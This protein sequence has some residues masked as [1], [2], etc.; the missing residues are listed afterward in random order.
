LNLEAHHLG[1]AEY[2]ATLD[3]MRACTAARTADSPDML[4]IVE[5]PPVY[6]L[7]LAG[8]P[9]HVLNPAGIPVVQADRGG[10][11][12]YHGPGQVVVYVLLDLRRRGYFVKEAVQR[13]EQAVIDTLALWQV[14]AQRVAGAPGIYTPDQGDAAQSCAAPFTGLAKIAALG[15]KVHKGCTYHGVSLNVAMELQPFAGINPCGY[16][17]LATTDLAHAL[18]ASGRAESPVF[19]DVAHCLASQLGIHLTC[20]AAVA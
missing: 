8:K 2:Q 3:A 11:V 12:T 4:W 15:L 19:A 14:D 9:E 7:G 20:P 5:H 1:R 16:A 18:R 17:G 10:Q 13:I 6:T